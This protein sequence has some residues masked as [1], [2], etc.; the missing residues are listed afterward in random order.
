[1]RENA[2]DETPELS[3]SNFSSSENRRNI[4]FGPPRQCNSDCQTGS[5][6]RY[7]VF[8]GLG[9]FGGAI[10]DRLIIVRL[11]L[12][13]AQNAFGFQFEGDVSARSITKRLL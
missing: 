6:G 7:R 1:M 3:A 12:L 5:A 8:P 2:S 4:H 10:H 13:Q 11:G 9:P